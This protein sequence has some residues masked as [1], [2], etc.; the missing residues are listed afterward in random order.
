MLS[1]AYA[2]PDIA[3]AM[4]GRHFEQTAMCRVVKAWAKRATK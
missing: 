2:A 3:D 4:R 1:N